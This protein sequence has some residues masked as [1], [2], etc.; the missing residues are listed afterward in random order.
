M[1]QVKELLLLLMWEVDAVPRRLA[2]L[3]DT[4]SRFVFISTKRVL[5]YKVTVGECRQSLT[6]SCFLWAKP[7][8][9]PGALDT[10]KKKSH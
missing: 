6:L 10:K 9:L 4:I 2:D 5:V 8:I 1:E 3:V 7:G